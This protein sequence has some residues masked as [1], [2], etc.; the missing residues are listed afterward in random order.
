LPNS[1]LLAHNLPPLLHHHELEKSAQTAN[2]F[3]IS[4]TE[5][6]LGETLCRL[7]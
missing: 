1:H 7:W 2:T 3:T 6:F 5:G 4:I